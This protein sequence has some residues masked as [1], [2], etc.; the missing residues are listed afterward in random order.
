MARRHAAP[1]DFQ[2]VGMDTDPTPGDPDLIQGVAQRYQDIGD[3][4]ERALNVLKKDGT[5]AQARGAAMD[6]LKEM[7]GDDLPDKLAKTRDSYQDAAQAYKNYIPRL[8]E[9]QETFDR[10]V[11]Q[12]RIA[13]PRANLSPAQLSDTSTDEERSAARSTQDSID[14]GQAGLSAARSLA[15]QAKTMRETAQQ[16]CADVLDRAASEAI[17]ERNVFQ[18]IGDFFEDFPFVQILLGLLIAVV[19]V[20]FP[21]VGVLL[22]GALF[23]VSQIAAL[24]N[25]N[26]SFGDFLTGLVGII[27]GGSL[28]RAGGA[29]IGGAALGRLAPGVVKAAKAVDSSIEGV[30]ATIKK[31]KTVGGF[32]DSTSGKIAK[33][34]AGEFV[35]GA[36]GEAASQII[37]GDQLD[38]GA[39]AVA[40]T[41]GA[42]TGGALAGVGKR[43]GDRPDGGAIPVKLNAGG[44]RSLPSSGAR[45][46][47]ISP[48]SPFPSG[49][50][51]PFFRGED[52]P[53]SPFFRGE[54]APD[55]PFFR[56]LDSP[57]SPFFRGEDAPDSPFFRGPDSPDS[58]FFRGEDAPD[59]P[60]VPIQGFP[61]SP[62]LGAAVPAAQ[63]PASPPPLVDIPEAPSASPLPPAQP[64]GAPPVP[65]TPVDLQ[66]ITGV[67]STGANPL[68]VPQFRTDNNPLFRD[69]TRFPLTIFETGFA[70]KDPSNTDILDFVSQNTP[71]AF[72]STTRREELNFLGAGTGENL[73]FRFRIRAPGGI[74]IN[75]TFG[76]AS[77]LAFQ[78]EVSF[79]GG[80][81]PE[82][83]E[84][85]QLVKQ[86]GGPF[87]PVVV[88]NF[89]PNPNFVPQNGSPAAGAAL[90]P[91]PLA[92]GPQLGTSL[93]PSGPSGPLPP[94]PSGPLP[95]PPSG[96]VPAPDVT[97]GVASDVPPR[98]RPRFVRVTAPPPRLPAP[99]GP[100]PLPPPPAP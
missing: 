82:F 74:D 55:S 63:T 8:Q 91:V 33:D 49:P 45:P 89:V 4:A 20:F 38:V 26:F 78:S 51:S 71:S 58:P 85:A 18:K 22:G 35:E 68:G 83:I 79:P 30:A 75:R 17:P 81:R 32:L 77:P 44:T 9:A 36:A 84:G 6:S 92:A 64:P 34:A 48:G 70:P 54:D 37:D 93:A 42:L 66:A 11:D 56:G 25:G 15:E 73:V 14:E 24:A 57:D 52:S 27:P 40:G 69:D 41:L 13:A 39:I 87:L 28:L 7:V 50:D 88:G 43:G 97:S 61:D 29:V 10:A 76:E 62:A 16:V 99:G 67:P 23:A 65:V 100:P 94:P 21:V 60:S 2:I 3:A 96:P 46:S 12:A 72:V 90:P 59:S 53:D 5:I 80:I 86:G 31:S 95:P 98:I 19:S 47:P 1:D